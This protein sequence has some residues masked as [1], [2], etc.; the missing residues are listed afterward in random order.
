MSRLPPVHKRSY[1]LLGDSMAVTLTQLVA[2][3]AVVRRGSVTAAAE[4]LVVTQPSVS[5]A[6]AALERELGVALTERA[7]RTLRPT[8]AGAAYAPY[9]ADVLG[10]LDQGGRAA[11]E[12]AER[13]RRT[14]RIS[15]VTTAG[16]FL[17]PPLI[18]GFRERHPQLEISLDV[19][20]RA[21][22]FQRLADHEV[23]VAITGRV[24]EDGRLAGRA[25][26]DNEWV[27]I[28]SPSDPLAKRRWVAMEELATRSWLLR[29]PGS[30]TRIL[31]EE[32][33]S[34]HGIEPRVL[35][36]GSNGAIKQAARVGLGVALQS[37]AAVELELSLGLLGTIR[38]RGGLPHRSWYVVR[39]ATGPVRDAVDAFMDFVDS[40]AAQHALARTRGTEP[41]RAT[42]AQGA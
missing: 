19:G 25:F 18:Q 24:P 39:A 12:A 38:P 3:L 32:Y 11:R 4:E 5:A 7:G 6:V 16:E 23:D 34:A 40:P 29:E 17:V 21:D 14:L 27:L 13:G 42:A 1:M 41:G 8:P 31:C 36:L 10:L 37:R 33:L 30:G 26:M 22:V 15:A 2:F 9:A 35:T 20:N 28:T